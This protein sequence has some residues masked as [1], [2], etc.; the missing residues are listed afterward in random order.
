M[1][2]QR[3]LELTNAPEKTLKSIEILTV[4]LKDEET[5][6]G[7]PSSDDIF[8][9]DKEVLSEQPIELVFDHPVTLADSLFQLLAVE[10]L[11]VTANV[12]NR[13]GILQPTGRH[14]HAFAAYAQ[15]VGN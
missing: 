1:P 15:H 13:A 9:R 5:P 6:G 2:D 3:F 10:D 14:G 8:G 11:D 4:L 12:T 7:G